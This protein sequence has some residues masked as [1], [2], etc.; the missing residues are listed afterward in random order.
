MLYDGRSSGEVVLG[1]GLGCGCGGG[2]GFVRGE[3]EGLR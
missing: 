1:L 3:R 2:G